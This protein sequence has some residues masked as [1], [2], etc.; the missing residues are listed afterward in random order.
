[1]RH[2]RDTPYAPEMVVIPAGSFL[3][4]SPANEPGR[5]DD[6]GPQHRVTIGADFAIGCCPV[7][8]DEW[9]S[10]VA[11]G[12]RVSYRLSDK[13]RGRGLRP[14]INVS[15][16]DAQAYVRWLSQKT[17]QPYRLPSEAEWEYAARAGTETRWSCGD[18][19]SDVM[20]HA[21]LDGNSGH[22]THPVGQKEPN[23][24]GL[25]DMHGNV[26]EWV[27]DCWHDDYHGSPTDGSAWTLSDHR[28]RVLR[29]GSW[30]YGPYFARSAYRI[31]DTPSYRSYYY[32]FRIARTITP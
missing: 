21:W 16:H 6:E 12:G 19:E 14:V 31:W 1:M 17:G 13:G 5:Y 24:F 7:T 23:P 4:G 8:F 2:F 22:Q 11:D 3:M 20:T 32:G 18:D 10:C 26:W 29:G 28:S 27:E 15:W 25:Y 9:D 30:K